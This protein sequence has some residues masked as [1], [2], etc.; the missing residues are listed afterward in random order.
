M[1]RKTQGVNGKALLFTQEPGEAGACIRSVN[2]TLSQLFQEERSAQPGSGWEYI[3]H[4]VADWAAA[5]MDVKPKG[6]FLAAAG[7]CALQG[8]GRQ[9]AL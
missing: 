5:A 3:Q 6:T 8:R 2:T 9:E 4:C 1:P 7:G